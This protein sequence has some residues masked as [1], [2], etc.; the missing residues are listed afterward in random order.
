M[1]KLLV[2]LIF[3]IS[4]IC[5]GGGIVSGTI[6]GNASGGGSTA[7]AVTTN[8]IFVTTNPPTL[9][10]PNF[11]KN[12]QL[13]LWLDSS[14]LAVSGTTITNWQDSYSSNTVTQA[15]ASLRPVV[16]LV[17][18]VKVAHF[19]GANDQLLSPAFF[20]TTWTNWT[21]MIVCRNYGTSVGMVAAIQGTN[22]NVAGNGWFDYVTPHNNQGGGA[23]L[24]SVSHNPSFTWFDA[25]DFK[26]H[27][28]RFDGTNA[29]FRANGIPYENTAAPMP[30]LNGV[31]SLGDTVAGGFSGAVDIAAVVVWKGSLPDAELSAVESY[32]KSAYSGILRARPTLLFFGDSI[33]AGPVGSSF[34][35]AFPWQVVYQLANGNGSYSNY[36]VA[37]FGTPGRSLT[38]MF[39]NIDFLLPYIN[40]VGGKSTV[41]LEGGVN[42]LNGESQTGQY[43][44]DLAQATCLKIKSYGLKVIYS[45]P[46]ASSGVMGAK[47]TAR[48]TALTLIDA[49]WFNWCDGLARVGSS[50]VLGVTNNVTD[51]SI[52]SDGTHPTNNGVYLMTP[53]IANAITMPF[54]Q[55]M[56][57]KVTIANLATTCTFTFPHALTT[58]NYT[59]TLSTD[60]SL[61][62]LSYYVSAK[63]KTNCVFTFTGA[64]TGGGTG[65]ST[66][67][68]NGQ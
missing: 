16:S 60:F 52:F 63:T 10:S 53:I 54:Q 43:V 2:L 20:D 35:N 50:D 30:I 47:E 45:T 15:S 17:N 61:G 56:S 42:D 68:S 49:D 55:P 22:S 24:S 28:V 59:A 57:A 6:S 26:I 62:T 12:G 1:K 25:Y 13:Y 4:L 44:H 23:S 5:K 58:T 9:F 37:I 14:T 34:T 39:T 32:L 27:T 40:S 33:T 38:S 11:A 18:G 21:M 41:V 8:T 46:S 31:L 3:S 65:F 7:G 51:T 64:V 67:T 19:D 36:D 66:V 48:Q 29:T